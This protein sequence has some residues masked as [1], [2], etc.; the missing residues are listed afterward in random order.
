MTAHKPLVFTN[1]LLIR[2][3]PLQLDLCSST[4]LIN[5]IN[6]SVVSCSQIYAQGDRRRRELVHHDE[7]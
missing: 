7:E 3:L 2:T 4:D 1:L 5:S 6:R